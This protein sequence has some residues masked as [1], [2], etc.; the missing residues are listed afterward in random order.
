ML[1]KIREMT[2]KFNWIPGHILWEKS[3][4]HN[5]SLH[6]CGVAERITGAVSVIAAIRLDSAHAPIGDS[7]P[8]SVDFCAVAAAPSMRSRASARRQLWEATRR[9]GG[10]ARVRPDR[11]ER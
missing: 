10:S 6:D 3:S 4:L 5:S 1:S 2:S 7:S 11:P 8:A 9:A